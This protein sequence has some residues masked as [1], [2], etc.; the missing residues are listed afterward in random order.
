MGGKRKEKK[1]KGNG[2]ENQKG[3]VLKGGGIYIESRE[4]KRNSWIETAQLL[5]SK[6]VLFP[7]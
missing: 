2:K 6:S 5:S 7:V 4:E 1:Q 3:K